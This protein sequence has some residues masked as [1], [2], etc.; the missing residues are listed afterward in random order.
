MQFDEPDD[1]HLDRPLIVGVQNDD[2]EDRIQVE[3]EEEAPRDTTSSTTQ[4]TILLTLFG[5]YVTLVVLLFTWPRYKVK[6]CHEDGLS[7]I[8]LGMG[9][10]FE[11]ALAATVVNLISL[12]ILFKK[13]R[14]ISRSIRILAILQMVSWL[15]LVV[16]TMILA[17]TQ[18]PPYDP[19]LDE[20]AHPDYDCPTPKNDT[21]TK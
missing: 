7:C 3:G 5:I 16:V 20:H 6:H 21:Y 19:C 17:N 13:W 14:S 10:V 15:L 12:V 4:Q 1:G 2:K 9:L 18:K 8:A 11:I